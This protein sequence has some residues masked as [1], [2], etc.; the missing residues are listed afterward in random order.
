MKMKCILVVDDEPGM[1]AVIED[2]LSAD[3]A[4]TCV[5]DGK[6]ALGLL[7]RQDFD[8]IITDVLMPEMDGIELLLA[9]RKIKPQQK[10]IVISGG[11]TITGHFDSLRA[12]ELLGRCRGLRKPFQMAELRAATSAVLT[13]QK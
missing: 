2:A 12:A 7:A 1:R 3:Y 11:N 8:L 6:K 4:I 9:M 13:M 5:A 10:F